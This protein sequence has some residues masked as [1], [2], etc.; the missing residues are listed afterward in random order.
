MLFSG[1]KFEFR[2]GQDLVLKAFSVL[3]KKHPDM[4]LLTAWHNPWRASMETMRESPHIRFEL[5]GRV[6]LSLRWMNSSPAS[7]TPTSTA[8]RRKRAARRPHK[9]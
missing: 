9:T 2:K 4:V 8:L 3:S 5:S 7:N 6:G 1:G